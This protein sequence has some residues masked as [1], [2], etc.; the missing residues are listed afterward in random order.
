MRC[1]GFERATA[2]Y[3]VLIDEAFNSAMA[4]NAR[5]S[6]A[7]DFPMPKTPVDLRQTSTPER[8]HVF[9]HKKR[10]RFGNPLAS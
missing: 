3:S 10:N 4:S 8:Q 9:P 6:F 7:A 5:R 1:R 2:F